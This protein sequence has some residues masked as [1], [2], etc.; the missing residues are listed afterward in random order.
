[1]SDNENRKDP[2]ELSDEALEAVSGGMD[3]GALFQFTGQCDTC[4]Y[5]SSQCAYGSKKQA[6][7]ELGQNANAKCPQKK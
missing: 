4:R 5:R 7:I 6:F 1:M 2:E 3:L